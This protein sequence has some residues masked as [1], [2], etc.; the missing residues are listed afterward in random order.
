[1]TTGTQGNSNNGDARGTGR[2]IND[3]ADTGNV[4]LA[5]AIN[6]AQGQSL[7]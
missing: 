4:R 3:D 6:K 5:I 1:M 2:F 7:E